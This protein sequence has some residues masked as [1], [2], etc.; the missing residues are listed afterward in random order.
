VVEAEGPLLGVLP[1]AKFIPAHG[2]LGPG[3]A[4]LLY[5]DGLIE[6]QGRDVSQGIDKLLGH[7]ER[8]VAAGFK[9][10]AKQLARAVGGDGD[11][12]AL[13]LVRRR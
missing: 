3:D 4:F 2:Q 6:D 10:G 7:A 5:T 1:D 11:D 12:R 13:V 8:L 9:G